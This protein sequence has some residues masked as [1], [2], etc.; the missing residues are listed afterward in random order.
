MVHY[1]TEPVSYSMGRHNVTVA[2]IIKGY[3]WRTVHDSQIGLP[4]R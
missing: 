1:E 3:Q 2:L 4:Y